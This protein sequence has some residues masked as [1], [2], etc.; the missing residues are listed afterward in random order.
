MEEFEREYGPEGSWLELFSQA[1]GYIE[2]SLLK[3]QVNTNPYLII[4][5]WRSKEHYQQ[6][7]DEHKEEYRRVDANCAELTVLETLLGEFMEVA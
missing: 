6:F 7:R 2:T 1:P 4:D 5:R 3:D